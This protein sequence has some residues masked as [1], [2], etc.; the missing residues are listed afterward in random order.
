[1]RVANRR[2]R[3]GRLPDV[4]VAYI[5]VIPR[6]GPNPDSTDLNVTAD[7]RAFGRSA[8]YDLV[9]GTGSSGEWDLDVPVPADSPVGAVQIPVRVT[10]AQ[11][12]IAIVSL[13]PKIR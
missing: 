12:R 7:L 10:D 1:V 9:Y 11:G 2:A 8:T 5:T 4:A 6:R 3:G 13:P